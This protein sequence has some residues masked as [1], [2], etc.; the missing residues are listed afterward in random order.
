M[1]KSSQQTFYN[2][3]K[4][5]WLIENKNR[6][7]QCSLTLFFKIP[8]QSL[9]IFPVSLSEYWLSDFISINELKNVY[10]DTL[11][12][13]F[14]CLLYLLNFR[15][16]V[17]Y[18]IFVSLSVFRAF[19]LTIWQLIYEIRTVHNRARSQHVSLWFNSTVV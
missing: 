4:N 17:I 9:K 16:F 14:S 12:T 15:V 5:Y 13:E 1:H 7:Y 19:Y 3:D 2:L 11:F 18:W 6:H 10:N 8:F